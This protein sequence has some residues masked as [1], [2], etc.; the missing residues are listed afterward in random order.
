MRIVA[1]VA[2]FASL[3]TSVATAATLTDLA[4]FSANSEGD[5]WNGL[6]WNTQG[7][8]TDVPDR[9]NLYV[10][11]DPLSNPTP[12]FVNS[13]NTAATRIALPLAAGA[14]TFSIYGEGVDTTFDPL[15]HFVLNLFFGGQT[16]PLIS[17][18][19]NLTNS[20]L[21]SAGHPNGLDR[22]GNSGAPEAGVLSAVIGG[23]LVTLTASR[24]ITDGQRDVVWPY[25]ANDAPFSSGSGHLDYYGSF[26]L[27][28]QTQ[29]LPLPGT[30]ALAA[31]ALAALAM[32]RRLRSGRRV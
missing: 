17:G 2:L 5:N 3:L 21:Q 28:V 31:L 4:L 23:E 7:A 25:W 6:I 20:N 18:V 14:N 12:L 26:T 22:F 32:G 10:T 29:A 24:W 27:Q 11:A 30:P 19:Q 9:F 1:A 15:Q 13:D 16:V 8:D